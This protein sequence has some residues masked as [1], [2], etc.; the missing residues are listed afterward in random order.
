MVFVLDSNLL[1]L[2]LLCTVA[3]Q[4]LFFTIAWTFK[5]DKVTDVRTP[6]HTRESGA[7]TVVDDLT[8]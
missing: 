8:G 1:A 7:T 5:F 6:A 2:T 3:M 4:L